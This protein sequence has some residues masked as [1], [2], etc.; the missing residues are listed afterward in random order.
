MREMCP[1]QVFPIDGSTLDPELQEF[2]VLAFTH[3][4]SDGHLSIFVCRKEAD[5]VVPFHPSAIPVATLMGRVGDIP[6]QLLLKI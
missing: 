1:I 4:G 5:G 2:P 6:V 3:P